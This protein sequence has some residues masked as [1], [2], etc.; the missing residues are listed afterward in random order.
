MAT[1]FNFA[2]TNEDLRIRFSCPNH[3]LRVKQLV[4]NLRLGASANDGDEK[5]K[6]RYTILEG[7]AAFCIGD[8]ACEGRDIRHEAVFFENT[9]YP[10]IVRGN[11][12][13]PLSKV[14]LAIND[15]L[16]SGDDGKDS[17]VCEGGELYG[18][19]NFHNQV[20]LTDFTITYQVAGERQVKR[21]K[22]QTEVLS[23]KLDYRSDLRVIIS[24]IERE[25]A[26]L[27]TS[28]LKDTY[29]SMRRHNGES[30]SL[31][32]WQIFK[33]CYAGIMASAK[34]IIERP[35][36]RLR[37]TVRYERA[38][39]LPA[40][41]R[42]MENEYQIH[43]D[44]PPYLYRT[45]ELALSHDTVENRFLKHALRDM[46]RKFMVIKEHIMTAMYMDDPMRI[47]V[48][49]AEMEGELLRL[50]NHSFFRGVGAFKGFAQDSLVMKQA[51]G[52]KT[53][54]EKWIE[55]QQGYELEDGMRK[56][57]VKDISDL[58]EIW[59]FIKVKNI[60]RDTLRE[61]GAETAQRVKG[62]G[63]TRGFIPQLVYGGS[64]AFVNE[65]DVELAA[66]SYNAQVKKSSAGGMS[67]ISG[68]DTMTTAQRPDIVLRLSKSADAGMRY[69]YL[70]DA[71]YRIDDTRDKKGYDMPP[72]DAIDQMHR[73]RD[74]IYYTEE[75]H[76]RSR[77][78]KEVIAAYVLFPGLVPLEA[79][80]YDK[81][82]YYYQCSNRL[83]GIGAFPLRP[84]QERREE[85]GS[86]I[87]E[88]GSSEIALR[89]QIRKW[90]EDDDAMGMLLE[91]SIPQKG[92]EYSDE[93]VVKGT[94][95][96]SK[97]DPYAN[98]DP[99]SIISGMASMF[100]SGYS[101]VLG[102]IDF[103][104]VR[105]LV[106]IE[107]HQAIGYYKVTRVEAQDITARLRQAKDE[108]AAAGKGMDNKYKGFDKSIRICLYLGEYI[109]LPVPFTY[110]LDALAAKGI[111]LSRKEFR[112]YCKRQ[113]EK[114]KR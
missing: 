94:Y 88:P 31:V 15:R 53:I 83:I 60:V 95:F 100:Y 111:V 45:E 74:A 93:P 5:T 79:M 99:R 38:E 87:I 12:G 50:C 21:L 11:N 48:S 107:K 28:F 14:S 110:G 62:R 82:D 86:I 75:G 52:Y 84:D 1:A 8:N 113:E 57:E 32:W 6:C 13:K 37:S 26:M 54:L 73:Y 63:I 91:E 114:H 78:K 80:D 101:A 65:G 106:P 25:Y 109:P 68:T 77:L 56:L 108:R 42:E 18:S 29:L 40:L 17:I 71:K 55:L 51:H 19:L 64:V 59:C 47:D 39:R 44:H 3:A 66:V 23:Y 2:V 92:L 43:K 35:K 4:S 41:P 89:R 22:F 81:G 20:G 76:D 30:N 16:S 70:F 24:D 97:V 58:Y 34:R 67:A 69:T 61:L 105:Y 96:L 33:S 7:E 27:S 9:E 90:L 72:E 36:R 10:L 46:C 104:K 49:L 85:D 103:Q 102:G 98:A 112:Q